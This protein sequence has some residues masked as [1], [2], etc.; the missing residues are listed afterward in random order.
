MHTLYRKKAESTLGTQTRTEK[1]GLAISFTDVE[2]E[3]YS[4]RPAPAGGI[5]RLLSM[6]SCFANSTAVGTLTLREAGDE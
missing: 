5:D 3:E 2:C 6:S 1:I 4:P